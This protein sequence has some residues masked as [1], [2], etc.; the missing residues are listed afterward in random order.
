MGLP[1][2]DKGGRWAPGGGGMGLPVDDRGGPW[3]R[4]GAPPEPDPAVLGGPVRPPVPGWFD[5][6][7]PPG[8]PAT[9]PGAPVRGGGPR[10]C[11]GPERGGEG[12]AL[13]C[14]W[15]EPED[16][17][18]DWPMGRGAGVSGGRRGALRSA[19]G[20]ELVPESPGRLVISRESLGRGTPRG[21]GG[22][23]GVDRGAPNGLAGGAVRGGPASNGGRG[24]GATLGASLMTGAAAGVSTGAGVGAA[25]AAGANG[26]TSGAG[27]VE[28]VGAGTRVSVGTRSG[29]VGVTVTEGSTSPSPGRPVRPLT[30]TSTGSSGCLSRRS[31]S[32]SAL[33]RTRS[34]WASSML[35]EWLVTPI[36]RSRQRSS[37][38]LLVRPSSRASSY[39]RIFLANSYVNPFSRRRRRRHLS[40]SSHVL[41]PSYAALPPLRR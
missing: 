5:D 33:R 14:D 24:A 27:A 2:G 38:S 11:G 35:D 15:L 32:R 30:F 36:P 4:P 16:D 9:R 40:L 7:G 18:V 13:D 10:R 26:A 31:P 3:G 20:M 23:G 21:G 19:P 17:G 39:T 28:T 37:A 6:P 22:M 1:V 25:T 41:E 8:E 29:A 12:G 34:P